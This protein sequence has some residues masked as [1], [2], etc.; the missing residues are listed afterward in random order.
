SNA[1]FAASGTVALELAMAR[2][3]SVIAYR[4]SPLTHAVV[5][6]MVKVEH[7][8]LLN[9]TLGRTVV[10]E[11]IQQDC[12]PERLAA[13]GELLLSDAAARNAQIEACQEALHRLGLGGISPGLRAAD[14][15]LAVIAAH[16]PAG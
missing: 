9:L 5:R 16:A 10:P 1:A 8:H 7:A 14:A 6:G 4:G 11:L 12:T 2:E 13:A 15:V 3:P